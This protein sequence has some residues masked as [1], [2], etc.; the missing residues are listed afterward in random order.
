MSV[1]PFISNYSRANRGEWVKALQAHLSDH[2]VCDFDDCNEVSRHNAPV[3]IVA[4]PDP[5]IL[6]SLP[7]LVWV[8]SLW[9]GVEKMLKDSN[10]EHLPLVRLI[11]P[12]LASRMSEAVLAWTLYLHRDMPVYQKQQQQKV[13]Q[14]QHFVSAE[15]RHLAVLG[16]GELGIAS[17]QRLQ[18]NQFNVSAW[19]R[20]PKTLDGVA[21]YHG[22][23]G[24][25]EILT[26]ADIVVCLLP[27]TDN[28]RNILDQHSLSII[29]PGAAIINFG[30]G[31]LID[32]QALQQALHSGHVS[33]AVLDVFDQE[34][35]P[36]QSSLWSHPK[37]TIL[38]HI[39]AQTNI[40]TASKVAAQNV[41]R[42]FETGQTP[43][44]VDRSKGY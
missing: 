18:Q 24:L 32:H 2:T 17:I 28:T 20:T 6:L 39:S 27:L 9:A 15:D 11:D 23:Q 44:F 41:A 31:P 4:D 26:T 12:G 10:L 34:P 36:A 3:C 37:I 5:Q 16:C 14:A 19:S 43:E 29:K 33:H 25:S 30:R 22:Q 1:V 42:W 21:H 13:W 8:Q 35:L 40:Q 38:P 7:N